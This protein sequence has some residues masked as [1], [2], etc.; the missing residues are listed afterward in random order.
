MGFGL[1]YSVQYTNPQK[2][3]NA[4]FGQGFGDIAIPQADSNGLFMR[5]FKCNM[6]NVYK[7]RNRR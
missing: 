6:V 7:R 1:P 5:R 4:D 3:V 2:L